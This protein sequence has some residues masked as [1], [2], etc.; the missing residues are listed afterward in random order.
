MRIE[1]AIACDNVQVDSAGTIV[2]MGRPV[3]T[4]YLDSFS[5]DEPFG[6]PVILTVVDDDDWDGVSVQRFAYVV[7][8]DAGEVVGQGDGPITAMISREPGW[9]P[10]W[11]IRLTA[12]TGVSFRASRPG[13][14][15]IS[16]Y[17]DDELQLQLGHLV[18]RDE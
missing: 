12:A 5:V 6:I 7:H 18:L 16:F 1:W 14:Y 17:L 4:T 2:R 13:A 3:E 8:D 10:S 15:L 9:P 11:P